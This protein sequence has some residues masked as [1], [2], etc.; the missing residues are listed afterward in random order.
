[1]QLHRGCLQ[2]INSQE[3]NHDSPNQ[4]GE[5]S[6]SLTRCVMWEDEGQSLSGSREHQFNPQHSKASLCLALTAPQAENPQPCGATGFCSGWS[7]LAVYGKTTL[8]SLLYPFEGKVFC[9][10]APA[11]KQT[12]HASHSC[13]LLR[14]WQRGGNECGCAL[15]DDAGQ[16]LLT[17]LAGVISRAPD[18][19]PVWV[20]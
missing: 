16:V 4:Q 7:L 18:S 6:S 15:A 20:G 3:P 10:G 1:M 5:A 8:N 9:A 14:V 12:P 2:N 13:H 11:P 19:G 17:M